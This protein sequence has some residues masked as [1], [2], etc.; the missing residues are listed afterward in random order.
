M[1]NRTDQGLA[2]LIQCPILGVARC[3][4]RCSG[5][6][7]QDQPPPR[8]WRLLSIFSSK[9]EPGGGSEATGRQGLLSVWIWD[10]ESRAEGKW[11]DWF[12]LSTFPRR[13]RGGGNVEIA[14][15][16]PRAVGAEGNLLLVFLRVHGPSFPRPCLVYALRLGSKLV[17][18]FSFAACIP[19]AAA[20]SVSRRDLRSSS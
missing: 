13:R 6:R 10:N 7:C 16:F 9:N 3:Q 19:V 1:K 4:S 20:V 14:R 8:Q 11:E 5:W 17:N 12:W 15:R 2:S 18:S